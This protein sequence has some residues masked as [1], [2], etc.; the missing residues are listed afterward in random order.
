MS[1]SDPYMLLRFLACTIRSPSARPQHHP[2]VTLYAAEP[3]RW[4]CAIGA[5]VLLKV[6]K[7]LGSNK[8]YVAFSQRFRVARPGK[9]AGASPLKNAASPCKPHDVAS[10]ISDSSVCS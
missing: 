1:N 4:L 3:K 8:D 5:Q 7:A 9:R 6:Y 2:C 10:P